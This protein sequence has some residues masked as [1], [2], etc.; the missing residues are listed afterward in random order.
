MRTKQKRANIEKL[1]EIVVNT[2]T[3]DNRPL[4]AVVMRESGCTFQ[5]IAEVMQYSPQMAYTMVA[6]AQADYEN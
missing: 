5:E 4:I 3:V 6:K 2:G 1:R